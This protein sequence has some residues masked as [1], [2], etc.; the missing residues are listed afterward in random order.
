MLVIAAAAIMGLV[1]YGYHLTQDG[2]V[3][4]L[5][6][7]PREQVYI[8]AGFA[9]GICFII[10]CFIIARML[11]VAKASKRSLIKLGIVS[12]VGLA[13]FATCV[14]G[15]GWLRYGD[16]VE[17]DKSAVVVAQD[18][19]AVA[20]AKTLQV[21]TNGAVVN[22]I[23]SGSTPK[24]ELR[25]NTR[26][27]T[28]KPTVRVM[29]SGEQ[30]QVGAF[31]EGPAMCMGYCQGLVMVNIYGPSL[32]KMTVVTGSATYQSAGQKSF[33]VDAGNQTEVALKGDK[34][35]EELTAV[36][37]AADFATSDANVANVTMTSDAQSRLA[38]GNIAKLT[39]SAPT[40]CSN[41][42]RLEVTASSA[43]A[44]VINGTA[45][46]GHAEQT[47]CLNI[48]VGSGEL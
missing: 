16:S 26:T 14:V 21:N 3:N 32:D 9:A 29:R 34:I 24:V 39:L 45:W 44:I 25:Y 20:G 30:L 1:S 11:F 37:D 10:F 43:Q 47:P 22:Y 46:Q 18:A 42:T 31:S 36:T 28:H 40:T 38:F 48:A 2:Q 5:R 4:I 19:T 15:Y 8:S 35:I 27:I 7:D 13:S 12:A 23:V 33:A 6:A 41:G 17:Y